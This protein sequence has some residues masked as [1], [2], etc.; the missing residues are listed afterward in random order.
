[1]IDDLKIWVGLTFIIHF[2]ENYHMDQK[3]GKGWKKWHK[4]CMVIGVPPQKFKTMVKILFA[5]QII[6]F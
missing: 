3:S 4:T 6:L 1:V 5:S 2:V